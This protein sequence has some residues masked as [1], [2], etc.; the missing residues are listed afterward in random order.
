MK[1]LTTILI[2]LL[3]ITTILAEEIKIAEFDA[4]D[5][6]RTT[7]E[8]NY[9]PQL[10]RAWVETTIYDN[11]HYEDSVNF[12]RTYKILVTGLSFD[13]V[14]NQ[15]IYTD[16]NNVV[17]VCSKLIKKNK[18]SK[19]YVLKETHQCS[20]VTRSSTRTIDDGFY[21]QNQEILELY[22]NYVSQ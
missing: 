3:S 2:I 13:T 17:T 15:I 16:Q 21:I 9:N 5:I 20:F 22:L 12:G 1:L 18:R 8:F 4:R 7:S 14:S 6:D 10:G 19:K 11:G